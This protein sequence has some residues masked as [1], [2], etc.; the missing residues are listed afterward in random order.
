VVRPG[1]YGIREG[2]RLSSVLERAGG[3]RSDVYT[4][5]AIMERATVREIQEKDRAE[6]IGRVK[7]EGASLKMAPDSDPEQQLAKDAA[8]M[9]WQAA[10]EKLETMPPTGRMVIHISSDMKRW[11]GTQWDPVLRNGDT[12]T[13]PKKPNYV[14]VNGAVYNSTA[15]TYRSSK[16]VGWYLAQAGGATPVANKKAIF[17][18]R[19]DGSVVAGSGG[20]FSGGVLAAEVRPGDMLVVPERAYTGNTKWKTALQT[21]QVV[22]AIGIA[23]SVARQF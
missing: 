22:S 9:Q 1:S 21:S 15:I 18:V 11:A 4:Y 14:M 8:M 16:P 2:E 17:L 19:A 12:I 10:L 7:I 20:M 6:L 23:V 13:F 3:F 5:G